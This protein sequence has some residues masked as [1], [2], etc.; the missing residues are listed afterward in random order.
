ETVADVS[1]RV[2]QLGRPRLLLPIVNPGGNAAVFEIEHVVAKRAEA[3]QVLKAGPRLPTKS[4][5]TDGAAEEDFHDVG[6]MNLDS[7]L[8]LLLIEKRRVRLRVRV[9]NLLPS[10]SQAPGSWRAPF[11]LSACIGTMNPRC[12][13]CSFA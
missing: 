8:I 13:T 12:A 9:R 4:R 11:R 3:E 1:G 7:V 10:R 6:S 5:P 2:I